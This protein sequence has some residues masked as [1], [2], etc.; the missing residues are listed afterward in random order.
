MAR[1]F[2]Q[3]LTRR[4]SSLARGST[5]PQEVIRAMLCNGSTAF[6]LMSTETQSSQESSN[7]G[8]SIVTFGSVPRNADRLNLKPPLATSCSVMARIIDLWSFAK[9]GLKHLSRR[10]TPSTRPS[11]NRVAIESEFIFITM[12]TSGT[13]TPKALP[14]RKSPVA[15]PMTSA[16]GKKDA[17][18]LLTCSASSR[19]TRSLSG[20]GMMSA[21]SSDTSD[22]KL[23]PENTGRS[24]GIEVTDFTSFPGTESVASRAGTRA[25]L[26]GRWPKACTRGLCCF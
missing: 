19:T 14:R 26:V 7:L 2:A 3:R 13:A 18:C 12:S 8:A 23:E 9:S 24:I 1:S 22:S 4:I 16:P 20:L 6:T 11:C 5:V 25:A 21:T 15:K 10:C 17:I